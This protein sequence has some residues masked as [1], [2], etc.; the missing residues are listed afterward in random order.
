VAD[1]EKPNARKRLLKALDKI[2]LDITK[3]R[4]L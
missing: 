3:G 1:A 2:F 4:N